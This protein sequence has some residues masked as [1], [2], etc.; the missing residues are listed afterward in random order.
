MKEITDKEI[1]FT[2]CDMSN[3][4]KELITFSFKIMNCLKLKY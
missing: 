1:F 3:K 2:G 4:F